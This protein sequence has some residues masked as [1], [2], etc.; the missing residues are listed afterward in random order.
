VIGRR[1]RR[2]VAA[3]T[4]RAV[5]RLEVENA[6]ALL[7]LESENL[8]ALVAQYNEGLATH[9]GVCDRLRGRI[10]SLERDAERARTQAVECLQA[11]DRSRAA[12]HALADERRRADVE[13]LGQE[14]DEAE[15]AYQELVRTRRTAVETAR[16]KIEGLRRTIGTARVQTALAELT[17][18]AASLHGA[19]GLAGG[20]LDRLRDQMDERRAQAAGRVRVAREILDVEEERWD[21][22]RETMQASEALT[23]LEARLASSPS[24]SPAPSP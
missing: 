9:A 24:D 12:H 18:M 2:V 21:E 19:V 22:Q 4:G 7:D 16:E 13:R 1:I 15:A 23:R 11:G 20:D 8:R 17:E 14:L 3:L 5:A 10:A 6:D